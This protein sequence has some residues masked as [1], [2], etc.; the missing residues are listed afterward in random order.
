M[1]R[2]TAAPASTSARAVRRSRTSSM[3]PPG[4]A[5]SAGHAAA[6]SATVQDA[7]LDAGRGVREQVPLPR[8]RRDLVVH[9]VEPRE[10]QRAAPGDHDLSVD[11]PVVDAMVQP[12]HASGG[13]WTRMLSRAFAMRRSA[14]SPA[15]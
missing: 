5:C 13:R 3:A 11:E 7:H 1:K 2:G 10:A 8:G 14:S 15:G 4:A 6:A 9:D 12:A